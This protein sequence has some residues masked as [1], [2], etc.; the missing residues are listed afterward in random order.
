M[1]EHH[2]A[3]RRETERPREETRVAPMAST[4]KPADAM[5]TDTKDAIATVA[6]AQKGQPVARKPEQKSGGQHEGGKS[7]PA[8]HQGPAH[9]P[10]QKRPSA[11][12][13]KPP[14]PQKTAPSP[15]ST[16]AAPTPPP[17]IAKGDTAGREQTQL[18]PLAAQ[19]SKKDEIV[20]PPSPVAADI[21]KMRFS[22][23][24]ALDKAL[25]AEMFTLQQTEWEMLRRVGYSDQV[26]FYL[27]TRKS[28]QVALFVAA[29]N[30]GEARAHEFLQKLR[31]QL[32]GV[33]LSTLPTPVTLPKSVAPKPQAVAPTAPT[34]PVSVKTP[35]APIPTTVKAVTTP[36]V[37]PAAE[38]PRP[39]TS[40]PTEVS[41]VVRAKVQQAV[42]KYHAVFGRQEKPGEDP[43][44]R[45]KEVKNARQEMETTVASLLG[46]EK[47]KVVG[48]VKQLLDVSIL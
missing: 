33:L 39:Q 14:L 9:V 23:F 15:V 36:L 44:Q 3:I 28:E 18:Q 7:T 32:P 37:A 40:A 16:P 11:M 25:A 20:L 31:G 46:V 48:A 6:A 22:D 26:I 38:Q 29:V 45:K 1:C 35:P 27:A 24:A 43:K 47:K 30:G 10:G 2:T 42:E 8:Q 17:I 4:P 12:T 19:A 13:S 5:R 21:A 41:A 34:P